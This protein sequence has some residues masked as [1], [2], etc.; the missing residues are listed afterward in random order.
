MQGS[1]SV[2][3]AGRL[4]KRARL[5]DAK[6]LDVIDLDG[7]QSFLDFF[8]LHH[9][10]DGADSD[11][12]AYPLNCANL[13]ERLGDAQDL[14]NDAAVDLEEI[15]RQRL[16]VAKTDAQATETIEAEAASQRLEFIGKTGGLGQASD[17][18]AVGDFE[19]QG[20]A[21]YP[22]F[23]QRARRIRGRSG[24]RGWSVPG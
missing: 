3:H 23:P 24:P 2:A 22:A 7:A 16:D 14:Q 18:I 11:Y 13:G 1:G 8:A 17:G 5:G 10:G 9:F 12:L 4:S 19:T 20:R 21:G 6:T 15:Q